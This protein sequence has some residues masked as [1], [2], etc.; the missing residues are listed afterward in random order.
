[1]I[2]VSQKTFFLQLAIL[3]ISN[4]TLNA[5]ATF[6]AS[7]TYTQTFP[8]ASISAVSGGW[9]DNT[10]P[11]LGLYM[12]TADCAY[13]GEEDIVKAAPTNTGGL[14]VYT[15]DGGTIGL[16]GMRPSDSQTGGPCDPSAPTA[17]PY[18]DVIPGTNACTIGLRLKNNSG[19]TIKSLNVSFDWYQLSLADD[20]NTPNED[21]FDYKVGNTESNTDAGGTWTQKNYPLL[22][23]HLPKK[24]DFLVMAAQYHLGVQPIILIVLRRRF[25]L[26]LFYQQ[27]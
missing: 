3:F 17:C 13:Q 21:Y 15:I 18:T 10:V 27:V 4:Q 22:M 23:E 6:T 12:S 11:F 26:A 24:R 7:G 25:H 20:A 14:Y 2:K 16:F 9:S 5:Q 1:M 8:V 19:T